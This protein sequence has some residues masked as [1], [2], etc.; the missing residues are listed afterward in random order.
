MLG[1]AVVRCRCGSS[2]GVRGQDAH[3]IWS[4]GTGVDEWRNGEPVRDDTL[5]AQNMFVP[6]LSLASFDEKVSPFR[7]TPPTTTTPAA[8][9][10][11][12]TLRSTA[13]LLGS[14][15]RP[16]TRT[17]SW[18]TSTPTPTSCSRA[19]PT[20]VSGTLRQASLLLPSHLSFALL[21]TLSL[22]QASHEVCCRAHWR[23]SPPPPPLTA[24]SPVAALQRRR[25][26][27]RRQHRRE[28]PG[29]HRRRQRLHAVHQRAGDRL[30]RGL[31]DHRLLRLRRVLR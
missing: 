16:T 6:L 12:T 18:R 29:A 26:R 25:Y 4:E 21:R 17:Y 5:L 13:T 28:R 30:L 3:W 22:S 7:P 2:V 8:A 19:W 31:D 20:T 1:V 23:P 27:P 24:F 11:P 14:A 15:T 9:S 10:P